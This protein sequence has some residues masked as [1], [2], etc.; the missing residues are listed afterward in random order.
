[1]NL[2]RLAFPALRWRPTT[3]F[4]HEDRAAVDYESCT[5]ADRVSKGD[6]RLLDIDF[7]ANR[8]QPGAKP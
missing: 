1:M 4:A 5:E 6:E 8:Q 3:G 7:N 2:G